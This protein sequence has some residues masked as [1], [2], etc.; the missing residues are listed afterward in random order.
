MPVQMDQGAGASEQSTVDRGRRTMV[1]R[2]PIDLHAALK[3]YCEVNDVSMNQQCL[4][5]IATSI[6]EGRAGTAQEGREI[7]EG[8]G[9]IADNVTAA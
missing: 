3:Q 2:I 5:A 8:A 6:S 1:V 4:N 7:G 9:G